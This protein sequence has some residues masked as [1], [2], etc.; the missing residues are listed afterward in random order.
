VKCKISLFVILFSI[1][2]LP[3]CIKAQSVVT[4]SESSEVIA[5][6]ERG[7]HKYSITDNNYY[8]STGYTN[9]DKNELTGWRNDSDKI[10]VIYRVF[11]L[12]SF[13]NAAISSKYLNNLQQD[14][15]VIRNSGL[16]CIV[17]FDYSE[18]ESAQPQQPTKAQILQHIHQLGPV[19]SA[20][21]DVILCYEAGYIGTWGEWYYTNSTELGD[22][23][24]INTT[25][26]QNRKEI[27]DS[28]LATTPGDMYIMLRTPLYKQTMYGSVQLNDQTAYQHTAKARIG[29]YDDSFLNSWGDMGTFSVNSEFQNPVGTADYTYLSNETRY[30]PMSGESNGQ[31]AP[32]TNGSNAL[33]ELD[34]ANWSTLNRDYYEPVF[35]G[36]I[37]SGHYSTIIKK[38]GYRISLINSSFLCSGNNLSVNIKLKNTGFA[39]AFNERKT[40]L[41]LKN[42]STNIYYPFLM[43]TDFRTWVDTVSLVQNINLTG[44]PNGN[45]SAYLKLPDINTSLSDKPAYSV[46]LA[47]NNVWIDSLGMNDLGQSFTL[48]SKTIYTF[49]GSGDWNLDTNWVNNQK[50]P[51]VLPS[52]EEII[53]NP[54]SGTDCILGTAQTI[55]PGAKITV[56]AGK[57][58]LIQGNLIIQ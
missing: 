17:R 29:F 12:T 16:K 3:V 35:N 38:M 26:L 56:V 9:L 6:P 57:H 8:T 54:V 21:K 27:V 22:Q 51:A 37:S 33:I 36:W 55:S 40:Y 23:G 30:T 25:Q 50:P 53:I 7:F 4:Y 39:K 28:M 10:T 43:N 46:R 18:S 1:T 32:R 47:N 44:L 52:N 13:F 58:F 5:N 24:S 15:N 34:L 31:N 11:Q 19:L 42:T 2:C 20:N 48:A 45:Y 14:F 41:L 49:V